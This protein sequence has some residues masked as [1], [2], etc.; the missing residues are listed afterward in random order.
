MNIIRIEVLELKGQIKMNI[1]R[2]E[3]ARVKGS[4]KDEYH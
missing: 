4:D 1:I 2:I 3:V